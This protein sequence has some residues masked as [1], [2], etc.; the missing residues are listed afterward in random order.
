MGIFTHNW[1]V[2]VGL[3]DSLEEDNMNER[4]LNM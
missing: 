1:L 3:A 2:V 4:S